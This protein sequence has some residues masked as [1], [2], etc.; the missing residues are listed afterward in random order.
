MPC[1][2]WQTAMPRCWQLQTMAGPPRQCQ[3]S[4]APRTPADRF[5]PAAARPTLLALRRVGRPQRGSRC[6]SRPSLRGGRRQRRRRRGGRRRACRPTRPLGIAAML[7]RRVFSRKERQRLSGQTTRPSRQ[8][9]RGWGRTRC[10]SGTTAAA[11]RSAV[12][13]R[14]CSVRAQLPAAARIGTPTAS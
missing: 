9:S 1:Q 10:R 5:T 13:R 11:C 8:R 12:R 6:S 7:P 14:C 4:C 3:L 2:S